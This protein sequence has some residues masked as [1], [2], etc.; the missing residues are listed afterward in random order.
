MPTFAHPVF[1]L[2]LLS[3]PLLVWSW[4]R[5][6][7][8]A[9][10]FPDAATL[11]ALPAGRSRIARWGGALM[12]AAGLTI[13]VLAVAGPRWPDEGT[14][15]DTEG[16]AIAMVVDVSGNRAAPVAIVSG[17]HPRQ[18]K[19]RYGRRNRRRQS[20]A[21]LRIYRCVERHALEHP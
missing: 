5:R 11:A 15:L 17:R 16:I 7:R 1:L 21:H 19:R 3:V 20:H 4:L 6:H 14:R 18:S 13:L 8:G 12:R 9:L 10:R 2:S